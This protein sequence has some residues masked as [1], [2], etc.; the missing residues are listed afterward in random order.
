MVYYCRGEGGRRGRGPCVGW[1][2]GRRAR[3][4][5]GAARA[6]MAVSCGEVMYGAY[7]PYLYGRGAARSFHHAP[8]FQ[9]DRVS[10]IATACLSAVRPAPEQASVK[11]VLQF[12][13]Q[14]GGGE[15][16]GGAAGAGGA[17]LSTGSGSSGAHSPPA[18]S[19]P[20]HAQ[21]SL[22]APPA[23]HAHHARLRAKEE[24]LSTHGRGSVDGQSSALFCLMILFFSLAEET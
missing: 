13:V 15:A 3:V 24:D 20:A 2:H 5:A 16:Y 10:D 23:Q 8:H 17:A 18:Q 11:A 9:Y 21:H 7:Y 19:P 12:N 4:A 1:R 14:S 22:H 6:G